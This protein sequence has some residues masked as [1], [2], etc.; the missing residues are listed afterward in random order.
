MTKTHKNP[1]L[2]H[3]NEITSSLGSRDVNG[4]VYTYV[5]PLNFSS[6]P[7]PKIA[8][9]GFCVDGYFSWPW[10]CLGRVCVRESARGGCIGAGRRCDSYTSQRAVESFAVVTKKICIKEFAL[11]LMV[12]PRWCWALCPRARFF[13]SKV[14]SSPLERAFSLSCPA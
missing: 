8:A 12:V 5:S 9:G 4:T 10:S 11:D 7:S 1:P 13:L 3:A 14:Q 2:S 6:P